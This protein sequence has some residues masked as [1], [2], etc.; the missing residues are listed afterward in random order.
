[1]KRIVL[2]TGG[3]KNYFLMGCMLVHGLKEHAPGRPVYFL[4]FGLDIAQRNFLGKICTVLRRPES[5]ETMQNSFA[6]K[7]AIGEFL[8]HI[9]WNNCVWLDCD[10]IAVG[11]VGLGLERVLR[12]MDDTGSEIA[13]CADSCGT[14]SEFIARASD[15]V[16]FVEALRPTGIALTQSYLNT[17]FFI[18]RSQDF[19]DEWHD[20]TNSIVPHRLFEQNAFNI[21]FRMRGGGLM[22][23]ADE[24][25]VHGPMLSAK[26]NGIGSSLILHPT[27]ARAEDTAFSDSASYGPHRI[28]GNVKLFRNPVLLKYQ[29]AVFTKFM[30][31]SHRELEELGLLA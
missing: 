4:D 15:I 22:L 1:M 31:S 7:G 27:S 20:L 29:E 16:P 24:W 21:T 28:S 8:R 9:P 14:I 6:L 5:L 2:V 10:M 12:Q 25:N 18:C 3:D 26:I 17:G 13:V 19:L 11:P 30:R 23:D